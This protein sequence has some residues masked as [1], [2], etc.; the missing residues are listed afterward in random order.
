MA[1][2][3]E[4]KIRVFYSNFEDIW[5]IN[6]VLATKGFTAP[7]YNLE[8]KQRGFGKYITNAGKKWNPNAT[9]SSKLF[10]KH[11]I[12]SKNEKE[13]FKSIS[14]I[15]PKRVKT[16]QSVNKIFPSEL[17]PDTKILIDLDTFSLYSSHLI[18]TSSFPSFFDKTKIPVLKTAELF[19]NS[20]S[21][22]GILNASMLKGI[23]NKSL[24]LYSNEF[25]IDNLDIAAGNEYYVFPLASRA[26]GGSSIPL[27]R[28]DNI[29]LELTY[30]SPGL[31]VSGINI[32]KKAS[33]NVTCR[34]EMLVTYKDG[35]STIKLY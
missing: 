5:D 8:N 3:Q 29:R 30:S 4:V 28:F 34:G 26:F 35:V 32:S 20:E 18:I 13:Y 25:T 31:T 27:D 23:T 6:N 7:I 21:F 19:L 16:S 22:S 24:G 11:I 10:G 17:Y 33:I 15:I 1:K 9:L 2:D 14:G 12:M